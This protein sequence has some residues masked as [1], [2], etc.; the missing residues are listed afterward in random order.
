MN[1][2]LRLVCAL[3]QLATCTLALLALPVQPAAAEQKLR[4]QVDQR[5]DFV[6]IGNTLGWDC[7]SGAATPIVGMPDNSIASFVSCGLLSLDTSPDLFW[8]ADAPADG[9]AL[10]STTHTAAD[11]RTTAV[12]ELPAGA[13]VTHAFLYWGSRRTGTAADTTATFERPGSFSMPVTA[14]ASY[15]HQR[16]AD[17]IYESVADVTSLVL[18]SGPGAYRVSGIDARS[19]PDALEDVLF[20]GWALV[21]F[22]ELASEPVRNL[23][24]FDGLDAVD[25]MIGAMSSA[26]LSGFLVP[27]A[28]FDAKLGT[29]VYEG[30]NGIGGDSLRF[31]VAPLDMTDNLHDDENEAENFFNGTR[32]RLGMPVSVVGDLPQLAGTASTMAGIDLDVIDVTDRVMAGQSSVDL[33]ALTTIDAFF[34]GAFITSISTF[35]PEFTASTKGVVD[36]NGG[37]AKAGDE[38]EYTITIDNS[39]N[40]DSID[41][42]VTDELP[43]G[44]SFVSGSLE[45]AS[46][47][48]AGKLSDASGD[49]LGSYDAATHTVTVRVGSGATATQGGS[50]AAGAS[51]E[52]VFRVTIDSGVVGVISNQASIEAAGKRGA[53][54]TTTLTDGNGNGPGS[55]PTQTP[56][57]ECTSDMQCTPALPVCDVATGVCVGCTMDSQC[58]GP[59]GSCNIDTMTCE[60]SGS[61]TECTDT[62]TDGVSDPDEVDAGTDPMDADSDDDGVTDGAEP[63]WDQ[64]S[65]GDGLINALDP[66]SDDDGLYDGTEL[67]LGCDGLGTDK[68]EQHCIADG[69]SGATKTDPLD[70]DTDDGGERDGSEDHD[71]DGVLELGERNPIVGQGGDDKTGSDQ[72]N[73]GLSDETEATIGSDP[74]D[75]DSDD[76]GLLDGEERNPADDTDG[77]GLVNVLDP[78]SD[79]DALRDGLEAGKRCDNA[80][81][82]AGKCSADGDMGATTTSP[83]NRDTDGGGASDGSEDANRN[84]VLDTGERDPTAGHADDDNDGADADSDGLSDDLEDGLGSDKNDADSDDDGL[85]DGE[86]NNPGEDTDGD[87][88]VNVID[89]DSDGDTL[90]DGLESGQGCDAPATDKSKGQCIA[91]GDL[92]VT[93]T[94]PLKPDTDDGGSSDSDEDENKNGIVDS[95]E[96]DPNLGCDDLGVENCDEPLPPVTDAGAPVSNLVA[97]GGGGCSCSVG[98]RAGGQLAGRWLLPLM[99]AAWLWT[100]RRRRG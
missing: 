24:I 52:I 17:A 97:L 14:V 71:L 93:T 45:I 90:P 51:T 100:R 67:G 79:D 94:S 65:D 47:P 41:T 16:G 53:P 42:V 96:R 99:A 49:D 13:T 78:D 81:T 28:G 37:A 15:M 9:Q 95:G 48:G 91:D 70:A 34:M 3:S 31:G 46:G 87:G 19:F 50:I 35:K 85:S 1:T 92:G 83:V 26:R 57:G 76:D 66:D 18:A 82:Q 12:L 7:A 86:E 77:D 98:P 27:M 29:I 21:V 23:A 39:G 33:Q 55:P 38:L 36:V 62:D 89:F 84:G 80:A 30:D 58:P 73:D 64:D 43:D 54:L 10:A 5:G 59:M 44:V 20:G 4:V 56:V 2:R 22:Y 40:D 74:M 25:N 8:R 72:D 61:S 11:A 88:K 60:C 32:S 63:D 68:A 75:A 6:M 69:D